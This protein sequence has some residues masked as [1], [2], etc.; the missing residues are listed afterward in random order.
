M[1][2]PIAG[3]KLVFRNIYNITMN[4][5]T[6][7]SIKKDNSTKKSES[8]G[9]TLQENKST[10]GM[11]LLFLVPAIL[12]FSQNEA[13][14][15][16]I[17]IAI[18]LAILLFAEGLV[19]LF[20]NNFVLSI[21]VTGTL[22]ELIYLTND[23]VFQCRGNYLKFSDFLCAG[24]A[25]SVAG[26]YTLEFS[27]TMC[28]CLITECLLVFVCIGLFY[29]KA[30]KFPK[31]QEGRIRGALIFIF[32]FLTLLFVDLSPYKGYYYYFDE[33]GRKYG[34]VGTLFV[35]MR[36]TGI[37]KPKGYD[38][39]EIE[40]YLLSQEPKSDE[41]STLPNIIVVMDEAFADFSLL[42][43]LGTNSDPLP[44]I[45]K[46]SEEG[47]D[48]GKVS[49]FKMVT[50]VWGGTT[51][52]TE[53]EFLTGMSMRLCPTSIP[54]LQFPGID[55]SYDLVNNVK[56]YGYKTYAFHPY[57]E[58]GYNRRQVYSNMGFED[59]T[60]IEQI[61]SDYENMGFDERPSDSKT[62][63]AQ[64]GMYVRNLVS[65]SY[66]FAYLIDWYEKN[67]GSDPLFMFNVTMQNH[68]PYNLP[69]YENEIVLTDNIKGKSDI[70]QY[71]SI[72]AKTDEAIEEL[73]SYFDSIDDPTVILIFGD[74]QPNL[75]E[76]LYSR[77]LGPGVRAPELEYKKYYTPCILY[78][79]YDVDLPK[80]DE[81][82]ANF[83]ASRLLDVAGIPKNT[84]FMKNSEYQ[85]EFRVFSP[86]AVIDQN[87]EFKENLSEGE[88]QLSNEYSKYQYYFMK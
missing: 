54:F 4:A 23:I 44:Y 34:L 32:T 79:N 8:L 80:I 24:V 18:T 49:C 65:D 76:D 45:H 69:E 61:D 51:V 9:Q 22:F 37:E 63:N 20:T 19:L 5:K 87:G 74:H 83:L 67:R 14:E 3:P 25:F 2:K 38:E 71:L 86:N 29:L 85:E 35:E 33:L 73:I 27:G 55:Y 75:D 84:W 15:E 59:M 82:S 42:G 46:I 1:F 16:P 26:R 53:W 56:E 72:S 77:I 62:K 57:Y 78:A 60:F 36:Q 12:M 50:P 58:A 41:L 28:R 21:L 17:F 39:K 70:E 31:K 10:L 64:E 81:I 13:F 66:N 68:G 52:N 30:Y 48:N 11:A 47:V 40:E 6:D 43:D 88:K 7:E